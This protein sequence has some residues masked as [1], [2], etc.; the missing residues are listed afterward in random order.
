[1]IVPG[2]NMIKEQVIHDRWQQLG[3]EKLLPEEQDY[4][5][6]W[7]LIAEVNNGSF[8][9]YF[10]N[11]TG[12]HAGQAL[13][14]LKKCGALERARLLQQAMD[15]F[16]PYGGYTPDWNLRNDRIDEL[17]SHPRTP[18]QGAFREVS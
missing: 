15:L 12:D 9:Q 4:I 10:G 17:E 13:D 7:W 3:F 1:M 16:L 8:A 18:A 6:I 11:E 5:M 2:G 14:G